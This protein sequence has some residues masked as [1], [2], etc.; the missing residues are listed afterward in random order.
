[1][2]DDFVQDSKYAF[3]QITKHKVH[4]A[5]IV[6]T[7][8]VCMGSNTTAYNFVVKL[9][10][11]PY[12]YVDEERIV[13]VGKSETKLTGDSVGNISIPHWK[14]IEEHATSF[15][16]IGFY[17]DQNQFD[18]DLDGSLRRIGT[19]AIT[20]GVWKAT[21]VRP[22]VGRLFTEEEAKRADGRLIVLSETLWNELGGEPANLMGQDLML[23]NKAYEI[24][25]VVPRSF[26]LGITPADGFIPRLFR[27]FEIEANQRNNHSH[28]AIGK[29]KPG[30]TIEQANQNLSAVF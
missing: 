5:I 12:D 6:L 15:T 29:L 21:G 14:F 9:V 16:H 10:S 27:P 17:D 28:N 7:L 25:G 2:W 3:R 4:T 24:I 30:V 8:A 13:L 20:E 26:F 23:D 22:I 19:D 11:K 18:L 1:M